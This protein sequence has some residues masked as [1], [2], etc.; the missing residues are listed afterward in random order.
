ML[1]RGGQRKGRGLL[2]FTSKQKKIL[3]KVLL[4]IVLITVFKTL[5]WQVGKKIGCQRDFKHKSI[6]DGEIGR[7]SYSVVNNQL[8]RL[9]NAGLSGDIR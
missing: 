4:K 5:I 7:G 2:I 1:L 3:L 6:K 9:G 8:L